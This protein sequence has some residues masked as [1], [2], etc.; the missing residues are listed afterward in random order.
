MTVGDGVT[1]CSFGCLHLRRDV[2]VRDALPVD[3]VDIIG[4]VNQPSGGVGKLAPGCGGRRKD[5][6]SMLVAID[7][8]SR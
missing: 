2:A 4:A 7:L 1:T 6:F 5:G 3:G 8:N